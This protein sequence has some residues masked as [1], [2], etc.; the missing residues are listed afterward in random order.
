VAWQ[1]RASSMASRASRPCACTSAYLGPYP[2]PT[3][4][5]RLHAL[6]LSLFLSL[7]LCRSFVAG[8]P[9]PEYRG[10]RTLDDL[11]AYARE[12]VGVAPGAA[13]LVDGRAAADS[14]AAAAAQAAAAAA[15]TVVDL[16]EASFDEAV[17]TGTWLLDFFAP[18]VRPHTEANHTQGQITHRGKPHTEANHTQEQKHDSCT[19]RQQHLHTHTHIHTYIHAHTQAHIHTCVSIY[20]RACDWDGGCFPSSCSFGDCASAGAGTASRWRRHGSPWHARWRRA[21][22]WPRLTAPCTQVRAVRSPFVV[23]AQAHP[24]ASH[25]SALVHASG[26]TPSPLDMLPRGTR[27]TMGRAMKQACA[28]R[29]ACAGTQHSSSTYMP[30]FSLPMHLFAHAHVHTRTKIMRA[31]TVCTREN[32]HTHIHT[33][34]GARVCAWVCVHVWVGV[35]GCECECAP[36]ISMGFVAAPRRA[37]WP[38]T[39]AGGRSTHCRTLPGA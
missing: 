13:A 34:M 17:R 11:S 16:T 21:C 25:T 18:Y 32:G 7:S 23:R 33:E 38:T 10:A 19:Q 6:F 3:S 22:Q 4:L 29:W 24:Q 27:L 39:R 5:L 12:H 15:R 37:C 8:A 35:G 14:G 9:Q 2:C 30:L 26:R 20:V 36:L 31:S 28:A 1:P